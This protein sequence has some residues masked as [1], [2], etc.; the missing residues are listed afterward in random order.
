[1]LIAN[2]GYYVCIQT[3][4]IVVYYTFHSLLVESISYYSFRLYNY[5]SHCE[6]VS[7]WCNLEWRKSKNLISSWKV[8]KFYQVE[9]TFD[10]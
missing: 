3:I 5:T 7:W 9:N 8:T 1:M 2:L 6:E 4:M 10:F